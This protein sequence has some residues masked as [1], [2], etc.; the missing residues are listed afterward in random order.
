M[1]V[2]FSFDIDMSQQNDGV[3]LDRTLG[4]LMTNTFERLNARQFFDKVSVVDETFTYFSS[5]N[6]VER[7]FFK[8]KWSPTNVNTDML[9]SWMKE[10]PLLT[11]TPFIGSRLLLGCMSVGTLLPLSLGKLPL[12]K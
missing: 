8:S 5:Q 6:E 1:A 12:S 2:S 9:H 11:S 3:V 10:L 4:Y 7:C